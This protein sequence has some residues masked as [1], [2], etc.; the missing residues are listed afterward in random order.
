[1]NELNVEEIYEY[2]WYKLMLLRPESELKFSIV[3][4]C[5]KII[6]PF[7]YKFACVNTFVSFISA[8]KK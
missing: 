8:I 2:M 3:G 5:F 1:M 7:S 4:I 6:Q